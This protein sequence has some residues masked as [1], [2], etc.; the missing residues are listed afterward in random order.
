MRRYADA[1]A[2][3]DPTGAGFRAEDIILDA[4]AAFEFDK[5]LK[6]PPRFTPS[7][8]QGNWGNV[9]KHPSPGEAKFLA[10]VYSKQENVAWD[11]IKQDG[12]RYARAVYFD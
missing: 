1:S 5:M 4:E 7:V 12:Q 11:I 8:F 3:L 10:R 6:N 9:E 2:A